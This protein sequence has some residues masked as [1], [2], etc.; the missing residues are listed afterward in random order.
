MQKLA[1]LV[2]RQRPGMGRSFFEADD[3]DESLSRATE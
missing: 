1:R 2:R 3:A